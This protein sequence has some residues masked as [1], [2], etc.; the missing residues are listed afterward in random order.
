MKD[1]EICL[2]KIYFTFSF[3]YYFFL[4]QYIT[5]HS[6]YLLQWHE[7]AVRNVCNKVNFW[8]ACLRIYLWEHVVQV[9]RHNSNRWRAGWKKVPSAAVSIFTASIE[10]IPEIHPGR[11]A[12]FWNFPYGIWGRVLGNINFSSY[13]VGQLRRRL[14]PAGNS[15]ALSRVIIRPH[16]WGS[17]DSRVVKQAHSGPLRYLHGWKMYKLKGAKGFGNFIFILLCFVTYVLMHS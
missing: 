17:Q 15:V 4:R 9:L 11:K 6:P 1:R 16:K 7:L 3:H 5:L 10:L 2:H 8:F 14:V 12:C 13:V